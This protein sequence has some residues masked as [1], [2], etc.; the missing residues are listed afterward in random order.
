MMEKHAYLIISD[1]HDFC[2]N[3]DNRIDYPGEIS[4]IK[5]HILRIG[6]EYAEKG[7]TVNAIL[8]GDINNRSYPNVNGAVL[9]NNY[10]IAA[11]ELFNRIYNVLGNHETTYYTSNPF[12]TL[13]NSMESDKVKSIYNKVWKPIGI[14]DV[15]HVIDKLEDGDV[16]F[17]FNHYGCPITYPDKSKFNIGLF[18]TDFVFSEIAKASEDAYHMDAFITHSISAENNELLDLYDICFFAHHHKLYGCWNI[19]TDKGNNCH[20]YHLASLGRPNVTEVSDNFLERNIPVVLVEDNKFKTVEDNKIT[21]RSRAQCVLEDVVELNHKAYERT[22][23]LRI[24]E[25]YAPIADDPVKNL[26]TFCADNPYLTELLDGLLV[27]DKDEIT[28]GLEEELRKEGISIW[29]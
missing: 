2:K 27:N 20:V 24:A 3:L 7:Y 23:A 1:L 5:E 9:N 18:H 6:M 22:K 26:Q 28:K 13:L 17:H 16:A 14:F 11:N 8:L 29:G 4:E 19:Q 25:D 12:F 21:L 15:F 10:W